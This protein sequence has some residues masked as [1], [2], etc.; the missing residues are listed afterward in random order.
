MSPVPPELQADSLPT[1]PSGKSHL[2]CPFIANR[3]VKSESNDSFFSWTPKSLWMVT[4]TMKL[5]DTCSLN[6]SY[7]KSGQCI[8]K[9]RHHIA[10][11][12]PYNQSYGFSSSHVQM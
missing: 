10:D 9:Q 3:E 6:E 1:E 2:P 11:K 5:K 4:A 8:E 7:D 12:G